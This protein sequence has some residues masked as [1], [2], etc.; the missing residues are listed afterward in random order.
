MDPI[1]QIENASFDELKKGR[2]DFLASLSDSTAA[3]LA[4]RF[5]SARIDAKQR[6]EKLAEQGVTITELQHALAGL[7]QREADRASTVVELE[8]RLKTIAVDLQS[9]IQS[10]K[11]V[12]DAA[13]TDREQ[14]ATDREQAASVAATKR[15][16]AAADATAERDTGIQVL[17]AET[18]RANRLKQVAGLHHGALSA[19]AKL[20]NDALAGQLIEDADVNADADADAGA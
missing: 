6:D 17:L 14:A 19:A 7:R 5:I 15:E 18:R 4:P 16:Q 1:I 9:R 8:A 11:K 13:A 3:N 10:H 2:A 20:L 12:V